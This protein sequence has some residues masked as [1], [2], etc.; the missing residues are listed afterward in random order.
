M[1]GKLDLRCFQWS[2][3]RHWD[4]AE[5]TRAALSPEAP[6]LCRHGAAIRVNAAFELLFR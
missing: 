3:M 6:P 2:P 1:V 4:R 5:L